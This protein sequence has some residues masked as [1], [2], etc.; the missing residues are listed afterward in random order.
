MT[1]NVHLIF[2]VEAF[3]FWTCEVMQKIDNDEFN[4]IAAA[5]SRA[6]Y[7]C[8]NVLWIKRGH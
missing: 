7:L 8:V 1:L 3:W 4:F 2:T 5:G 6:F